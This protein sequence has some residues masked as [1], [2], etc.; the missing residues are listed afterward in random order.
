MKLS[1][2]KSILNSLETI[3]FQLPNGQLVPIIFMLQK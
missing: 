1:E 3:A 2:I